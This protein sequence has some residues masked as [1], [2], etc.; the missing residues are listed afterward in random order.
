MDARAIRIQSHV[1]HVSTH[2][3]HLKN[4]LQNGWCGGR[5]PSSRKMTALVGAPSV[6]G[7]R[8]RFY[9]VIVH[10][11]N[12]H[13][14]SKTMRHASIVII[15]GVLLGLWWWFT[16]QSPPAAAEGGGATPAAAVG[17]VATQIPMAHRPSRITTPHRCMEM[18]K[19]F[20]QKS[21]R[22]AKHGL[23]TGA[24][25][26][27][28]GFPKGWSVQSGDDTG[29]HTPHW[30]PSPHPVVGYGGKAPV[31]LVDL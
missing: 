16:K 5:T 21:T 14:K 25:F 11:K 7:V 17:G 23:P 19:V 27:H 6:G 10:F 28:Y 29:D 15:V 2:A 22:T 1:S 30:N 9:D 8:R 18:A 3:L 4:R 24:D 26:H 20:N 31:L 13:E 12:H